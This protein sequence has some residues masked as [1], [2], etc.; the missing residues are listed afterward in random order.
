[1]L[2]N[3]YYQVG[4]PISTWHGGGMHSLECFLVVVVYLRVSC[5]LSNERS[6]FQT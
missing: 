2:R 4:Q 6:S 5:L 3:D 1:M